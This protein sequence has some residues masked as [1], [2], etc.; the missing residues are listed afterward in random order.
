MN[1]SETVRKM[2]MVMLVAGLIMSIAGF[3]FS[4]FNPIIHPLY[5]TF[6]VLLT[7][8][9]NVLKVVWLERAVQ[10]A[11]LMEDQTASSNYIRVHYL[12]RFLLTGLVLVAAV[13]IPF[14]DLFGA[15][16]GLFT[17]HAGKYSLGIFIKQEM[18]EDAS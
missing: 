3:V 11:V 7:T 8:G 6:G 15:I 2:I 12:L 5:F 17:Y 1:V 13:Y 18:N 16:F 4:I 9:L 10:A 14:I